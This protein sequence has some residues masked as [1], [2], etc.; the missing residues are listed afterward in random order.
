MAKRIIIPARLKS[1]RLQGKI[2]LPIAGKPMLQHVYERAIQC[3]F[4][5]V[6]VA[7]DDES[8]A[9]VA[10]GFGAEV[11]MT[12]S[13]HPTGT[14][15][16]AEAVIKMDYDEDDIIVNV[17]GDEP[18]IPVENIQQVAENLQFN[19]KASVATLCE[20]LHSIEEVMSPNIV[21]VVMDKMGMALY[22]SR[23]P[24]P[25]ERSE[26]PKQLPVH[27]SCY[28]HVGMYAYR[29]SFLQSYAQLGPSLIEQW[30]GLEQLRV[31]WN[32]GKIHVG[33]A[34]QATLP[35]VDTYEDLIRV[36]RH[37]GDLSE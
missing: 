15:R 23:A 10:R 13:L 20:P 12:S 7:T 33:I 2:L 36:R 1:G 18:L 16:L 32:G 11:C 24:I 27:V 26:F 31:L 25:W 37:L 5:S 17:Q 8:I 14:D 34:E 28:R 9:E 3:D 21:K 30:E 29:A 4:D 35:G 19:P 22:F 6:L